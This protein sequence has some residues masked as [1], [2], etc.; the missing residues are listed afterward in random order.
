MQLITAKTYSE[1]KTG[2]TVCS[3]MFNE[4]HELLTMITQAIKNDLNKETPEIIQ[5]LALSMVANVGGRNMSDALWKDVCLLLTSGTSKSIVRKKACLCLLKLF[6]RAPDNIEVDAVAPKVI[7]MIGDEYGVATSALTL[8]IGLVGYYTQKPPV[9]PVFE[10]AVPK[11]IRLLQKLAFKATRSHNDYKYYG[12]LCPWLQIRC[13]R[14]LQYFPFPS[15][16]EDKKRL[17]DTIGKI[18]STEKK[19]TSKGAK[20]NKSNADHAILFECLNLIIHYAQ[21]GEFHNRA[22]L[23]K[24]AALLGRFV[25][26]KE[27]NIRY[28]GLDCMARLAKVEGTLPKIQEQLTTIQYS[29]HKDL[30]ISIRKRAL[31]M[32]FVMCDESNAPKIIQELLVF[33]HAA[34]Y[35]IREELV[36]KIA[37]LAERFATDL[38]WYIDVILKL[39]TLAGDYIS[40]DIWYRVIQI[41]TNN[42]RLQKY[43]ALTMYKA[44]EGKIHENGIKVGGYIIGEFCDQMFSKKITGRNLFNV[45]NR[46]FPTSS[47]S[48][49]ALL[50]SAFVKLANTF[51]DLRP[52]LSKLFSQYKV[53]ADVEIQQRACE[54]SAINSNVDEN[55]IESVFEVMPAFERDQ[56]DNMLLKRVE[57]QSK[58]RIVEEKGEKAQI[59]EDEDEDDEDEDEDEEVEEVFED[60]TKQELQALLQSASGSGYL[61]S[62][63]LLQIGVKMQV[64]TGHEMKMK[65]F[66]G[67]KS[68]LPIEELSCSFGKTPDATVSL[69]PNDPITVEAKKQ[70]RQFLRIQCHR[71]MATPLGAVLRFTLGGEENDVHINFPIIVTQFIKSHL[72]SGKKFVELWKSWTHEA[73][74]IVDLAS[75]I[76][77]IDSFKESLSNR[78][79]VK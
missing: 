65:I 47:P 32:L 59:T 70:E 10:D 37:I 67:N 14:L 68:T 62:S 64:G 57:T 35:Q 63:P 18:L 52:E 60:Q 17:E 61:Y 34:E 44:L 46:H 73:K 72:C 56:S 2:Y 25:A 78:N 48:T 74:T 26:L 79:I 53:H 66:Y 49:Q 76:E 42:E 23:E 71:P 69:V 20:A 58:R 1:K 3:I 77:D 21:N 7:A 39:L 50:L 27:A 40:D 33:L 5:C 38:R 11:T 22:M 8:L 13:L 19:K 54:Y 29:L 41:V 75:N 15:R 16:D 43:A 28:L 6:K 45:L 30:D 51:E 4:R 9:P 55:L 36:L 24:A 12:T 31:D